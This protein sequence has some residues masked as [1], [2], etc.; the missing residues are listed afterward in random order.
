MW[1][2]HTWK[3]NYHLL[4]VLYIKAVTAGKG[5]K[6]EKHNRFGVLLSYATI[7]IKKELAS[8]GKDM[9]KI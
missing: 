8:V 5:E 1:D 3:V 2:F 7:L 9:I 4:L 6:G